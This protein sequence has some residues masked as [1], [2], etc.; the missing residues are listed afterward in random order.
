[1]PSIDLNTVTPAHLQQLLT[2]H[3]TIV[4]CLCAEW[5]DVCK[6]YRPRFELLASQ[7]PQLLFI[8]VDIEDQSSLVDDLDID[9]FPTLLIQHRDLVSFYGVMRPDTAQLERLIQA[10]LQQPVQQVL[11]PSGELQRSWQTHANLRQ[12]ITDHV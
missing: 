8:W 2:S 5:C 1:M 3:D 11:S 6:E 10:Q 7:F 9:N 12:R 4:A